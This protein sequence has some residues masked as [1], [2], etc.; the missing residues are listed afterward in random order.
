MSNN[1]NINGN[2]ASTR[3]QAFDY[4]TDKLVKEYESISRA[5][6]A[7]FI[8]SEA[9]IKKSAYSGK[10]GKGVQDYKEGKRYYFKEIKD[11]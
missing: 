9:S 1:F 2:F 3:V 5:A 7:L 4:D 6:R 11:K 8:H 10:K